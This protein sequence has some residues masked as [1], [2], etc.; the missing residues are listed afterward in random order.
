[1]LFP[2][3]GLLP[4]LTEVGDSDPCTIWTDL[5]NVVPKEKKKEEKKAVTQWETLPEPS[6][7]RHPKWANL[8]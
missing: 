6:Y 1:M 4:S 2:P 3:S 7:V 5:R 8:W